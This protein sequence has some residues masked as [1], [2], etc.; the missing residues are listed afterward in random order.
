MSTTNKL[1]FEHESARLK[2]QMAK[3]RAERKKPPVRIKYQGYEYV[4]ADKGVNIN[5]QRLA[6]EISKHVSLEQASE[7]I[8]KHKLWLSQIAWGGVLEPRFSDG[9][10]LLDF[11]H[12]RIGADRLRELGC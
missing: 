8:G 5:W 2:A 1:R 11:A 7:M 6:L 10:K 4:M 3:R 9:L 12:D